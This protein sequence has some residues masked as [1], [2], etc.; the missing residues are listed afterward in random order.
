[1]SVLTLYFGWP[2][3]A[4]YS[5][6]LASL[7]CAVVVFVRLKARLIEQHAEVLAQNARHHEQHLAQ[8]ETHHKAIMVQAGK[9]QDE[10]LA[11]ANSLHEG[12][13]SHVSAVGS[14]V[15]TA[16][17]QVPQKLLDDIKAAPKAKAKPDGGQ[18]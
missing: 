3:G 7:I 4:V 12:M 10:L 6:L 2:S 8:A 18:M 17:V 16:A 9:H 11:K 13:R 15:V 14:H 5:N 1:M